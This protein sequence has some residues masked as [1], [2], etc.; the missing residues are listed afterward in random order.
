MATLTVLIVNNISNT[1][2]GDTTA[3]QK[4]PLVAG[5]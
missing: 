2:I 5:L 3:K 1:Q 4:L